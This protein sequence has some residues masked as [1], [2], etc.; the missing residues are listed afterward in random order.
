MM[1]SG[2]WVTSLKTERRP[3]EQERIFDLGSETD[4]VQEKWIYDNVSKH[5]GRLENKI[6]LVNLVL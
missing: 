4:N 5:L 6:W 2:W 1:V 3:G